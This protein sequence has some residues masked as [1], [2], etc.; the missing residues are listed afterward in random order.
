MHNTFSFQQAERAKPGVGVLPVSIRELRERESASQFPET[1]ARFTAKRGKARASARETRRAS[2]RPSLGL[3][4][5]L[6][7]L[8]RG[9]A[10][11]FLAEDDNP[12]FPSEMLARNGADHSSET[13]TR[14]NRTVSCCASVP[15]A[16]AISISRRR[17]FSRRRDSTGVEIFSLLVASSLDKMRR[18]RTEFR[19]SANSFCL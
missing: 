1:G 8:G 2:S 7:R 16:P 5:G 17:G 3:G 19:H 6:G 10:V 11:Y 15:S 14:N 4:V 18:F 9:A 13:R 12:A